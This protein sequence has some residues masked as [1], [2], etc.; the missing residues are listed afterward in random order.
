MI[1]ETPR[2]RYRQVADELRKE[3]RLGKYP[4]GTLLPSQPELARKYGLNQTSINRAIALLRAEGLVRVE[5]GVGAFVQEIPTVKRVRRIPRSDGSGSSFAE[6]VQK[7]GLKP[8]APLVG[9]DI[10]PAPAMV[11]E[12]L[13]LAENDP[14]VRRRRHMFVGERPVQ[15]AISYIPLEIAGGEEIALPDTGP[16][17]LYRRLGD[18]GYPIERFV[19]EI[20]ARHPTE[21]EAEFLR[22]TDAQHVLEVVRI[23]YAANNVAAETVTNVLPSQQWRLSYE[24]TAS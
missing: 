16:S 13:G 1:V 17:G 4:A 10:V 5:H 6:E 18:R 9:L 14:V 23:A 12:R 15:L 21:E 3:I 11:A 7:V 24:W 20:E 22:L 8:H 19:E 2:A